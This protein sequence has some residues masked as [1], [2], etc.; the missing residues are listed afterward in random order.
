MDAIQEYVLLQLH[1]QRLYR[2]VF[3]N[4]VMRPFLDAVPGLH[5][6]V[7]L[8]KV[9]FAER[10]T[11][12]GHPRWDLVVV[13]APATGHGL[14]ML[15]APRAMMELT[16]AGP[17][18]DNAQQIAAVIEDP[19]RTALVLVAIPEEMPIRETLDMHE[20]LGRLRNL[21]GA[22]VLNEVH[23]LPTPDAAA[24]P[25]VREHLLATHDDA[26]GSAVRVADAELRI[27]ARQ[28]DARRR[29]HTMKPPIDLPFL[30][31]RDLG[32][33]DFDEFAGRLAGLL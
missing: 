29:L 32:R 6:L 26:L 25:H 5:D 19:S 3:Q 17:F 27:V 2:M 28:E 33:A 9:W 24:W 30:F 4:R 10:E 1:F 14:T 21:V 7:Q 22:V 16:V 15:G 18:H 31:R 23:P 13:D 11:E 8:G 20:R 12:A